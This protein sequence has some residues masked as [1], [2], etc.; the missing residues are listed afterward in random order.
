MDHGSADEGP[1]HSGLAC[2]L[3]TV[4]QHLHIYDVI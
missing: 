3:V 2:S 1:V 4:Y